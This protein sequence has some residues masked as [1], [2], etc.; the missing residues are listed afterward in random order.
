M[1]KMQSFSNQEELLKKAQNGDEQACHKLLAAYTSMVR[2][3][4]LHYSPQ[5]EHDD[6][7]QEG[8]FA[9]YSAIQDYN[10]SC[11]FST[12][13]K[14]CVD[15]RLIGVL[16][17]RNLKRNV[18]QDHVVCLTD[19]VYS[20]ADNPEEQFIS[21]E[22]E[23]LFWECAKT[24][25]SELE[26]EILKTYVD[27]GSISETAKTLSKELKTVNNALFRMRTKLKKLNMPK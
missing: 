13:S 11:G 24:A 7:F 21:K 9:L 18:P 8:M 23:A 10:F 16:R 17:R 15:R 25:L 19:L 14:L 4:V 20:L 2:A 27:C 22:Q 26:F 5:G 6:F 12:F 1:E 3:R